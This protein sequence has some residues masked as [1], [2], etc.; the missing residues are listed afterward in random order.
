M[1]LFQR[2]MKLMRKSAQKGFT[3]IELA[4]VGLFLGLLAVFAISQ[5]TGSATDTT[6]AK[7]MVTVATKSADNWALLAQEC[8]VSKTI[9]AGDT[10]KVLNILMGSQSVTAAALTGVDDACYNSSGI[11]PLT[12]MTKYD[13][14]AHKYENFTVTLSSVGTRHLGVVYTGVTSEV[15]TELFKQLKGGT[16]PIATA[17]LAASANE[18]LAYTAETGGKRTVTVIRPL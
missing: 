9:A 16:T 8:G 14:T 13:G 12:G 1:K 3:L 18:S 17:T 2:N 7:A 15:F 5:F 11:R 6:K 4:I 10:G